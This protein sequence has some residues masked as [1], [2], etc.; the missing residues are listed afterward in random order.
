M[1]GFNPEYKT[2]SRMELFSMLPRALVESGRVFCY[3]NEYKLPLDPEYIMKKSPARK[4]IF[5]PKDPDIT[6]CVQRV[7]LFKA[8]LTKKHLGNLL[9][10]EVVMDIPGKGEHNDVAFIELF[11]PKDIHGK[12][13]LV[14]GDLSTGKLVLKKESDDFNVWKKGLRA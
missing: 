6:N 5:N 13:Q 7:R 4:L 1:W 12:R 11:K 2:V 14:F 3:L 8:W 9:G 10:F